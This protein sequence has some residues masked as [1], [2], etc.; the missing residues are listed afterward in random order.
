MPDNTRIIK[1]RN[2]KPYS[3]LPR[4]SSGE[5]VRA[6]TFTDL[7]NAITN[8]W[9]WREAQHYEGGMGVTVLKYTMTSVD[10]NNIQ[11]GMLIRAYDIA[12]MINEMNKIGV[13]GLLCDCNCNYCGCNCNYCT[14]NCFYCTCNCNYCTCNCNWVN[15]YHRSKYIKED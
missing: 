15:C 12:T 1:F 14:C 9:N 8:E 11:T 13:A 7:I 5:I 10:V 3:A 6:K 2:S 4:V